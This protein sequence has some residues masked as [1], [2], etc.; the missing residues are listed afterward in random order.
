MHRIL[1][2]EDIG[3]GRNGFFLASSGSI[4]WDKIYSAMAE[5]L[6]KRNAIDDQ[7]VQNADDTVLKKMGEALE[8]PPHTVPVLLGGR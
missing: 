4:S 1:L 3:H 2:G 7:T 5:A 8:V 6:A